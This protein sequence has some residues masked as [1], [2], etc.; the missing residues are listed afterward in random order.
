MGTR[1]VDERKWELNKL[2]KDINEQNEECERLQKEIA[3][4]E[5]ESHWQNKQ[6]KEMNDDLIGRYPDDEKFQSL[7]AE[8]EELLIQ[9]IAVEKRFLE[10]S[11]DYIAAYRKKIEQ[12]KE[13]YESEC[14]YVLNEYKEGESEE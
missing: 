1:D 11:R 9:K 5:E 7:L 12:L 10:E 4:Y 8:K 6:I 3:N 13:E 2:L 14:E